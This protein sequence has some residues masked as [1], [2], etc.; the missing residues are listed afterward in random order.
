[1]VW[2]Y[3]ICVVCVVSTWSC[4]HIGLCDAKLQFNKFL[5]FLRICLIFFIKE[6][7]WLKG[8]VCFVCVCVCVCVCEGRHKFAVKTII[9]VIME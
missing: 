5:L 3:F 4:F 2:F 1:M 8:E 6:K 7:I 9:L